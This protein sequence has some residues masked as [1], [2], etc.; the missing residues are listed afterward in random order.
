[1]R[2]CTKFCIFGTNE[3]NMRQNAPHYKLDKLP[4]LRSKVETIKILRQTNKAIAALAELKGI[5]KT[6]PN[7]TMLINAIVI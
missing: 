2:I 1:M 6:I 5:A 3:I 7:Q 4:P